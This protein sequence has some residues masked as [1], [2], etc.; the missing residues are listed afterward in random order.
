M[1]RGSRM[2]RLVQVVMALAALSAGGV[3][4]S[5]YADIQ[6][7]EAARVVKAEKAAAETRALKE[8]SGRGKKRSKR[9]RH[10]TR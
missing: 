10:G 8:R 2:R 9:R 6:A 7:R 3:F 5:A 4:Y 1:A